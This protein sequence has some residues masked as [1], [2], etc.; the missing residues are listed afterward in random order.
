[1]DSLIIFDFL[2]SYIA[3]AGQGKC[4]HGFDIWERNT[5]MRP[6]FKRNANEIKILIITLA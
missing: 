3:R 4:L 5:K 6:M 2:I 1:M